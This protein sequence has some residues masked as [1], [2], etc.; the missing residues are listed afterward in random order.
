[1][2]FKVKKELR[3]LLSYDITELFDLVTTEVRSIV[4]NR[5]LG[6]KSFMI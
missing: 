6:A 1:M 5:G 4:G 3:S 2:S